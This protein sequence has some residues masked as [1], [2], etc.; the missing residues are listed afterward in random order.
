MRS[1]RAFKD[2]PTFGWRFGQPGVARPGH[3]FHCLPGGVA[4]LGVCAGLRYTPLRGPSGLLKEVPFSGLQELKSSADRGVATLPE[5]G[6]RVG[7]A[8]G[9]VSWGGSL[10]PRVAV[11][12]RLSGHTGVCRHPPL[13]SLLGLRGPTRMRICGAVLTLG[14]R[15]AARHRF[16]RATKK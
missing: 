1:G 3:A 11:G 6:G 9:A 8:P 16:S 5:A 2:G 14:L 7:E 12:V 4:T 15:F 10:G 13:P